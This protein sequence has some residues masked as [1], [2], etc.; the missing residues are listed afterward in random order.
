MQHSLEYLGLDILLKVYQ[1]D[2]HDQVLSI[3]IRAIREDH[4]HFI[5]QLISQD[6]PLLILV[7]LLFVSKFVGQGVDSLDD[8]H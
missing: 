4:G 7:F 2:H 5:F 6:L 8:G 3:V 1:L